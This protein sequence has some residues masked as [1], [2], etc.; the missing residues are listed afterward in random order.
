M[1][2]KQQCKVLKTQNFF[3]RMMKKEQKNIIKTI[4]V[5]SVDGYRWMDMIKGI[6][7][8]ASV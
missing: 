1:T 3:E 4:T 8:V 2:R 6:Y 7:S 5:I